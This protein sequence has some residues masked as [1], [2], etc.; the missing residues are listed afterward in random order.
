M[1]ER[2]IGARWRGDLQVSHQHRDGLDRAVIKDP[3]TLKFFELEWVDYEFAQRIEAGATAGE[4]VAH[5]QRVLPQL[6]AGRESADL[7]R[8]AER[9]CAAMY[10]LGLADH[11]GITVRATPTALTWSAWALRWVRRISAPMFVRGRLFDPDTLLTA[12]VARF[13]PLFSPTALLLAAAFVLGSGLIALGQLGAMEIR[14]EWF[15][16][17]QNLLALY[18]GILAL[19]IIHESGH[20]LAC[21]ALG[22]DVH[23]VGA[24]LLAFHPTFFVDVSD[25]WMWPD[26]RRR[27]AVAG[28][29][30]AAELVAAAVLFWL[31]M[32]LAPGF[33]RDLCM[34]LMFIA[35]V[36]AVLFN[37][38][39]LM[40]YDGYHMLADLVREPQLR[41]KSFATISQ[42]LRRWVFGPALVPPVAARHRWFF[43][44]Y[45]ILSTAFLIWIV[46]AVAGFLTGILAPYGLEFVG[47]ILIGAWIVSV[48]LPM[49][50]FVATLVRDT[51][52]LAPSLRRRP[53]AIAGGL[54]VAVALIAFVP[55]PVRVER[56]CVIEVSAAGVVRASQPGWISEILVR[57]GERVQRGQPLA[58]LRNRNLNLSRHRAA[59]E[60]ELARVTL[61]S[62][63]GDNH[64]ARVQQ[65]TRRFNEATATAQQAARRNDELA[66][67]SPCDGVVVTHHLDRRL[68]RM[69]RPGDELLAIAADGPR[70][71]LLPLTEK[72][73]RRV[74]EGAAVAFHPRAFPSLTLAGRITSAPLRLQGGELP[75]ALTAL[76]GG[77]LTVDANGKVF[78][79]EVTHVAR[80]TLS[81]ADSRL[82]PGLTGRARLDCGRLPVGEWIGEKF[83]DAIHLDYRW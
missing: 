28:A 30:F 67:I 26:R 31:W 33:A 51:A 7:L 59:G 71:C 64:A 17:W 3:L 25:T 19:K 14:H 47:R 81:A 18:L 69:L 6:C 15:G 10:R 1:S 61:L 68:G 20:A 63:V 50:R 9:L 16:S 45:G 56:E 42:T 11:G 38:N 36:S 8:R 34:N 48:A 43:A 27:I 23:E 55:L 78:S 76:A 62:S 65:S 66:L 39:P 35:S 49:V 57:E 52:T 29:G 60:V 24:Q 74:R 75:R 58:H 54:A 5:W 46:F 80:F 2:R 82:R 79:T 12:L 72:E 70:E 44:L 4:I 73:A 77:D 37:A 32:V 13:R 53:L 21:K 22:G 41:T 83:L 40:R